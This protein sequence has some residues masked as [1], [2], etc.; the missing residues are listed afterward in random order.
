[1]IASVGING[2]LGFSML[3]ATLFCLGDEQAVTDTPTHFPFMAVFHNATK[4]NAGASVMVRP[5]H[6]LP[7]NTS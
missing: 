6:L 1:M 5:P 4:S 3:I 2:I 7:R